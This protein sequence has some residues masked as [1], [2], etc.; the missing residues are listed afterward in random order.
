MAYYP[1]TDGSTEYINQVL[2]PYLPLV[3]A[4]IDY[5]QDDWAKLLPM[6]E[7]AISNRDSVLTGVSPFFLSYGYHIEPLEVTDSLRTGTDTSPV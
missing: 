1:E 2:E 4:F 6:A 5:T 7:L 3:R